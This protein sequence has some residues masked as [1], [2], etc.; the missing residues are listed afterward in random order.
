MFNYCYIDALPK[1]LLFPCAVSSVS[2]S[3]DCHISINDSAVL[4][5][6]D[7]SFVFWICFKDITPEQTGLFPSELETL[8]LH[9]FR[10]T[11]RLGFAIPLPGSF[12][13]ART[14]PVF[15]NVDWMS[16][17]KRYTKLSTMSAA[18]E[19]RAFWKTWKQSK[20]F[21]AYKEETR[22]M[23]WRTLPNQEAIF[24]TKDPKSVDQNF[25]QV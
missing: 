2:E 5:N 9:L 16:T 13:L 23:D 17:S 19:P 22:T 25:V 10:S 14:K 4:I 6:S 7:L 21:W 3:G 8:Y 18:R 1:A 20:V 24:P 11:E 12:G 15:A